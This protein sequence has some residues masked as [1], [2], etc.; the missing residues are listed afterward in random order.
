[1]RAPRT[2]PAAAVATVQPLA[3]AENVQPAEKPKVVTPAPKTPARGGILTQALPDIPRK[4]RDTINGKVIV[5][6]KVSVDP[7][8]SVQ[9]ATIEPPRSSR[10]LSELTVAAARRW[11][12]EPGD[13]PQE[14]LLRFQLFRDRTTV[15]PARV[16]TK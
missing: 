6:V 13:A 12:F 14:W 1:M 16:G 4:A 8:G 10:Y 15:S 2:Q 3:P 9:A 5:N 7:Q 11:K